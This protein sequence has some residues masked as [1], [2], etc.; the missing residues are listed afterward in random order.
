[1]KI[2]LDDG[3]ILD[4]IVNKMNESQSL[5]YSDWNIIVVDEDGDVVEGNHR[6][7]YLKKFGGYHPTYQIP[8]E[9]TNQYSALSE[10]KWL[11]KMH[12]YIEKND[13]KPIE[14]TQDDI[15]LHRQDLI[16]WVKNK[17]DEV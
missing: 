6:L 7:L 12:E 9:Y 4:Y 17:I 10:D 13:L 14:Y 15:I 1:M 3:P 11:E 5:D 8:R 16:D 2:Y